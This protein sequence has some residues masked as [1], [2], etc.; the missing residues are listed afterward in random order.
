MVTCGLSTTGIL[1]TFDFFDVELQLNSNKRKFIATK[2]DRMRVILNN[3]GIE[4]K[5]SIKHK[6]AIISVFYRCN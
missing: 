4:V 3:I 5:L 6:K 2:R 1:L